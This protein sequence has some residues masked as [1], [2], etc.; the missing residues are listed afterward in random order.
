MKNKEQILDKINKLKENTSFCN[1][2]M[3]YF[4]LS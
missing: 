2:Q 3:N 1:K 4:S